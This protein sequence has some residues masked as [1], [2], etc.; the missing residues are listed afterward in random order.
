MSRR[1]Q[2]FRCNHL[3]DFVKISEHFKVRSGKRFAHRGLL[4]MLGPKGSA[5]RGCSSVITF[6]TLKIF[7]KF[8]F[9]GDNRSTE[10][11]GMGS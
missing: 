10:D 11:G 8:S 6:W 7:A 9:L 5:D 2:I 3:L 4:P 1:L